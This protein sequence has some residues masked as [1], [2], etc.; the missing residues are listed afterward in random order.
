MSV[1]EIAE[2]RYQ[3]PMSSWPDH[4]NFH[5]RN[6]HPFSGSK[7]GEMFFDEECLRC[8]LE[9]VSSENIKDKKIDPT[10]SNDPPDLPKAGG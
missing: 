10:E 6:T 3:E 4:N 9:R 2:A 1:K 8:Q 5:R 7:Y